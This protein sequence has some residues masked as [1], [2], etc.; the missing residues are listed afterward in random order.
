METL[1]EWASDGALSSVS[2]V[3][4]LRHHGKPASMAFWEMGQSI[5]AEWFEKQD[6]SIN[7]DGLTD[8]DLADIVEAALALHLMTENGHDLSCLGNTEVFANWLVDEL[9][10]E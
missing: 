4:V 7:T 3:R 2:S 9:T 10:K 5:Y 8:F 1:K 6:M